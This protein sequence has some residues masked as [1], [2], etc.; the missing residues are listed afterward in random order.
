MLS[1]K[2]DKNT[3][4]IKKI[5]VNFLN[6]IKY[7]GKKIAIIDHNND[8]FTY[9][10]I[11]KFSKIV[12]KQIKKKSLVFILSGNNLE[13]IIF[14]LAALEN[15]CV[16][17]FIDKNIEHL[18]LKNLII[19]YKPNYIFS[20]NKIQNNKYKKE[21][22]F[23]NYSI[24]SQ[25]KFLKLK[26]NKNLLILL[27]TSGTTGTKKLVRQSYENYKS[28]TKSIIKGLRIKKNYSTITTLPI[29]YTFGLSI[30]NTHLFVG[31][32]II[33]NE[34]SVLQK[35]FWDKY[36]KY[37]PKT[38]YGVPF[39]YELISKIGLAKLFHGGL[40]FIAQAGGRLNEKTFIEISKFSKKN[41]INFFSMYGQTEGTARM[42]ILDSKYSLSKVGSIGKPIEGGSFFLI[43]DNGKIIKKDNQIGELMYKGSNVCLGYANSLSDLKKGDENNKIINTGDLAKFDE[44]KFYFIVGRTK[45]FIK[46]F[47][48]RI[49]LDEV[50]LIIE[51]M[52]HKVIC[53]NIDDCLMI[54]YIDKKLN[55]AEILKKL[56][57]VLKINPRFINLNLI[58]EFKINSSNKVLF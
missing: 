49:S 38:I 48:N 13:T 44:E 45:R 34:D 43:D 2:K 20:K 54:N 1:E 5:M 53:K 6:K 18:L 14:Y 40:K 21:L 29:S 33:L 19:E 30:I 32:T 11:E 17:H 27:T 35:S 56:S 41:K 9:T 36:K 51:K 50:E 10:E 12:G 55:K 22:D 57:K 25:K 47:G 8:K 31:S 26:V 28:N 3:T 39:T 37:L 16:I 42:S 58:Q 24:F 23:Y 46:I 15:N 52:G 4:L 7:Y